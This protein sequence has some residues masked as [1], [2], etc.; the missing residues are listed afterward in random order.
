MSQDANNNGA[1]VRDASAAA[2]TGEAG[3]SQ[4]ANTGETLTFDGW[5]AKQ[6]EAAKAVIESHTSGLKSALNSERETRKELE[7]QIRQ[8]AGSAQK[9]GELK[10]QLEQM[11][12]QFELL[13]RKA[14]FIEDAHREGV[15]NSKALFI[16]ATAGNH[17]D[18]KG[19]ADF[20]ALKAEFPEFFKKLVPQGNA[21]EGA[22]TQ[23]PAQTMNDI[24]RRAA[25]A[26]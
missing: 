23:A 18:K 20:A 9:E 13:E 10:G 26:R 8:L 5:I 12:A 17:F 16:L 11:S 21:G 3:Q 24:I 22:G 25:G 15:T 19:N 1:T 2:Q 4:Q 7:K 6:D 14:S